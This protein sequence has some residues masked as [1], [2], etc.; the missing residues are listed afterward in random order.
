MAGP[1]IKF[2]KND[3]E[4]ADLDHYSKKEFIAVDCEMMGLNIK[5]DRLCLVQIGDDENYITLVQI[6]KGQTEAPNLKKLFEQESGLKIFH[7][8]R[9]DLTWLKYNLDI[10]VNKYFCTKIA[11][12]IARTYTD[13]HSL[14]DLCKELTGKEMNKSLQ[15]SYWGNES[16]TKEQIEYAAN[17]VVHLIPIY[18]YL[19][20]ILDRENKIELTR[21]CLNFLP[22]IVELDYHGYAGVFD[23]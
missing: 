20:N 6:A 2:L 19:M 5:R 21:R 18:K 22:N 10:Q 8:A 1:K 12:K 3:L 17:D 14:K 11:S 23:H 16:Y 4:Q 13:K 15:S 7:Y 9:T